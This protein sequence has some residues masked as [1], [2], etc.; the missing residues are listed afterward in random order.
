MP[1][2]APDADGFGWEYFEFGSDEERNEFF[3][4]AEAGM[5]KEA[6]AVADRAYERMF[7]ERG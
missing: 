5:I 3:A 2:D 4:Y 7:Q 6:S 1:S